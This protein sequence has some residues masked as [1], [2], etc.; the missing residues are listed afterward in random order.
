MGLNFRPA[1]SISVLNTSSLCAWIFGLSL[2][3]SASYA[4]TLSKGT[5]VFPQRLYLHALLVA[6]CCVLLLAD[7][8]RTH[9]SEVTA[10][11][12]VKRSLLD[13]KDYLR[14]WNRGDPCRSNWTGVICFNEIGTDDYLH[15]R[16]L[17]EFASF[18]S[19]YVPSCFRC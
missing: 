17:Y 1:V 2:Y 3:L 19:S 11:R 15:V 18:F 9:P 12:S 10:L 14:N 5:M 8:Q 16:E 7:A 6:C 4:V 13:P